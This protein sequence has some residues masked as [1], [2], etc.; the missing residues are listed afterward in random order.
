MASK[1]QQ[2]KCLDAVRQAEAAMNEINRTLKPFVRLIETYE[3]AGKTR[4][5]KFSE[6]SAGTRI[7]YAKLVAAGRLF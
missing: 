5:I 2:D 6:L 4:Q 1:W 7:R 3:S